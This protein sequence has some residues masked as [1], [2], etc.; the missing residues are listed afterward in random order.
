[1]VFN[2]E[3]E[4]FTGWL[5]EFPDY[6]SQTETLMELMDNLMDI[7]DELASGNIPHVHKVG[8]LQVA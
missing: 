1:L 6:K 2:Q 8:E 5:E 7:Y 3:E 4:M